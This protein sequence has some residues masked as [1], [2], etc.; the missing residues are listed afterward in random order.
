M[1][2]QVSEKPVFRPLAENTDRL[3]WLSER[4]ESLVIAGAA[5]T[6]TDLI[7]ELCPFIQVGP[8]VSDCAGGRDRRLHPFWRFFLP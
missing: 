1:E 2:K 7:F 8:P 3:E 4:F 6:V 5:V